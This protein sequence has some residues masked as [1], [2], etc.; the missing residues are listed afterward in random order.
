MPII[1]RKRLFARL[2]ASGVD[3]VRHKLSIGAFGR[4]K[5]AAVEEW[6]REAEK[7]PPPD[8]YMYHP[9]EAPTGRTLH[10]SQMESLAHIGWVDTPAK[11]P[12]PSDDSR[13]INMK[14][15]WVEWEWLFKAVAVALGLAAALAAFIKA[16]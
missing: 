4:W 2:N 1:D 16:L 15:W 13:I 3:E 12:L 11:F 5:T 6:L 14:L 10:R 8:V 7:L 9:V